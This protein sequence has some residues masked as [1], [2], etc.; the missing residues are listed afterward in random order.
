[1]LGELLTLDLSLSYATSLNNFLLF[2]L[3]RDTLPIYYMTYS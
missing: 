3:F 2:D 1:M